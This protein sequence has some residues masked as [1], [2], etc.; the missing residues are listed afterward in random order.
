[1]RSLRVSLR[2]GRTT[3]LGGVFYMSLLQSPEPR[4]ARSPKVQLR[5]GQVVRHSRWVE[6]R[7]GFISSSVKKVVLNEER[8]FSTIL[9][10]L[11]MIC[12]VLCVLSLIEGRRWVK[13]GEFWCTWW[14][15]NHLNI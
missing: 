1:M 13:S 3:V 10:V 14:V 6:G 4:D 9:I 7:A 2:R 11:S 12:C 5:V 8:A 15:T